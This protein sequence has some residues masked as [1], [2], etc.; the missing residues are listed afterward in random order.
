MYENISKH[1]KNAQM[2]NTSSRTKYLDLQRNKALD[3][4][5]IRTR[6]I[7]NAHNLTSIFYCRDQ[8]KPAKVKAELITVSKIIATHITRYLQPAFCVYI[9][10]KLASKYIL[11]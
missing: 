3:N 5:T 7:C 2:F 9:I 6:H 4:Y 10:T 11:Q 8:S 1:V